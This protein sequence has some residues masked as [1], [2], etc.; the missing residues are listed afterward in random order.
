MMKPLRIALSGAEGRRLQGGDGGSTLTDV[1]GKA[2]R[3]WNN[4]FPLY[5]EHMLIK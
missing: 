4:E 1:Q 2:I 5:N 3:I